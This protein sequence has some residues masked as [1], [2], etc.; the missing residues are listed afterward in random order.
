[1]D[2]YIFKKS[3]LSQTTK[4][5]LT[6]MSQIIQQEKLFLHIRFFHKN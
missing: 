5:G 2:S 3:L 6:K 4:N 1:M